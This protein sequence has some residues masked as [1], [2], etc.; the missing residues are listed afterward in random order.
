MATIAY[1]GEM[2]AII[3]SYGKVARITNKNGKMAKI[4]P[5]NDKVVTNNGKI[6]TLLHILSTIYIP[7]MYVS[8]GCILLQ[9]DLTTVGWPQ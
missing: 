7:D 4:T 3:T 2:A 9:S 5:Y 6:A 8:G 1:Y